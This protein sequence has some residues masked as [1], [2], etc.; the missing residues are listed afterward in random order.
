MTV[1]DE[2]LS[3]ARGYAA[4]FAHCDLT[5]PPG[6]QVAVLACMNARPVPAV[7]RQNLPRCGR[8]WRVTLGHGRALAGQAR[9][10]L[11]RLQC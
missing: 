9:P 6:R 4:S 5:M 10:T 7:T 2:V 1:T 8:F 3:S 11:G